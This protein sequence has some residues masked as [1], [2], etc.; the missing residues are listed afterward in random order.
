MSGAVVQVAN[1]AFE[2]LS[3]N[4]HVGFGNNLT[5]CY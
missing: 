2:L 5:V 3:L 1:V 4:L